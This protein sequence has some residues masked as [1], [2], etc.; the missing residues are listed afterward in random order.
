MK[1]VYNCL[2]ILCFLFLSIKPAL[3]SLPLDDFVKHGDYLDLKLSPDGKHL[4]A[5]VRA[6]N[7]VFMVILETNSMKPVG[8]LKPDKRD[9]IHSVNW[10]SNARVG[11]YNDE[12]C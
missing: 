3:S 6:D 9:I 7:R 5:R 12:K 8:G 11:F 4:A 2:V 10:V 1:V